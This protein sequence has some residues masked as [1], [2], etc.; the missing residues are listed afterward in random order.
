MCYI[1]WAIR[2]TWDP[3]QI[4]CCLAGYRR[5]SAFTSTNWIEEYCHQR[6]ASQP[7]KEK[8]EIDH[9]FEFSCHL[10]EY[11][12]FAACSLKPALDILLLQ[13]QRPLGLHNRHLAIMTYTTR[14]HD[15]EAMHPN[16]DDHDRDQLGV[17]HLH[18]YFRR[19]VQSHTTG[20]RRT[21]S[22]PK[23]EIFAAVV[24]VVCAGGLLTTA[25]CGYGYISGMV[26]LPYADT[27]I[28]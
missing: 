13:L 28:L 17:V 11:I 12:I 1:A 27:N 14:E 15:P 9:Q 21:T 16:I 5:A 22:V 7:T 10:S 8:V 3:E 2:A 18:S 20:G 4:D 19:P 26:Y 24:A 23:K 25:F 6:S